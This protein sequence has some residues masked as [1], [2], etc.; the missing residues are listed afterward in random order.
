MAIPSAAAYQMAAAVVRF[1]ILLSDSLFSMIPAPIKPTPVTI[2]AAILDDEFGSTSEERNVKIADPPI[3]RQCVLMPAGLP[4]DS[5][6]APMAKPATRAIPMPTRS[7]SS[8]PVGIFSKTI[9]SVI[10]YHCTSINIMMSYLQEDCI[11][12]LVDDFH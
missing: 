4:R 12:N 8:Y 3:T 5:L 6:S 7:L 1:V 9:L 10:G 11:I 2:C